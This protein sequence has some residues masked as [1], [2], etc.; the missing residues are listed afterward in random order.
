[1]TVKLYNTLNR[2]K[3]EFTPLRGKQV[4]IYACGPTVYDYFHIGNARVFI[5]FDMIRRYLQYRGY[6]VT[7]V[8][9]FTDIEDKMIKRAAEREITVP[10]LAEEMIEAYYEDAGALGVRKA[11][12]HPMATEYINAMIK[13]IEKLISKGMAYEI[14]GDVYFSVDNF[15]GYGKLSR[16]P[17]EDLISGAR[18]D[19]GEEKRHPGDF[20]L[21]KNEK[22]GEPTW[23]SPWGKGRPGWHIECSVMASEILGETIDI[24][25]GGPDLIFP[26][27]ENEIAQSE[28]AT[29]KPFANYWLHVGYL[30]ID[31]EKMSKSK[32][33][34]LTVREMRKIYD[35]Q[36]IR[37]FM[38][39][40]HYR[41][42]INFSSELIEQSQKGLERLHTMLHNL[43][44][45]AS[46]LSASKDATLQRDNLSD[47]V[48]KS[49]A[50]FI[51]AM[52]DDIN[53][54]D[55]IAVLFELAREINSYLNKS[56]G[57]NAKALQEALDFYKEVDQV[58][59]FLFPA[60]GDDMLE[61]EVEDLITRRQEARKNKDWVAADAI[62][63][64]LTSLEI[65]IEDTP[66]G[67]RWRR[68]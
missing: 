63:E 29:G 19:V 2:S 17:L 39:S 37:F 36:A 52:D 62:R 8:Q 4:G 60:K 50:R 54:A 40:A 42:P 68:K 27:H 16:Q 12:H 14:N 32:G 26:H 38:L 28:S 31:K 35:P 55:G 5:V 20:A 44:D 25:G 45:R 43:E 41:H 1:M 65:I 21:W 10:Q 66:H 11:D 47:E 34:F 61:K 56:E 30:N 59:G 49:R 51:E 3:E 18:V 7:L 58:L 64:Q 6:E 33:N 22:P 67:V 48:E 23:D 24:H 53:T 13:L 9:N 46:K 57:L 15:S